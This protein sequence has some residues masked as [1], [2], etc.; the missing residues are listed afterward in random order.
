MDYSNMS[1]RPTRAL[2]AI[3]RDYDFADAVCGKFHRAGVPLVPPIHLEPAVLAYFQ[4]RA[5]AKGTTL[6][7]LV[8]ALLKKDIQL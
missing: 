7:A 8:N 1:K 5:A 2:T 4:S 6:S 3:K